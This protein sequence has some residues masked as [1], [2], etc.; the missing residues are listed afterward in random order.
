[1]APEEESAEDGLGHEVDDTVEDSFGVRG[2]DIA[3]L[4]QAP[5]DGIQE[6]DEDGPDADD[7]VDLQNIGTENASVATT[8]E[9]NS[10]GDK[11]EGYGAECEVSPLVGA[12]DQGTNKTSYNHN[13]VDENG[14]E[15]S[16]R[17]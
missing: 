6:P 3:T 14:V 11:E 16:W 7:G 10:P 13:L 12:L 15:D 2:N 17:R 4:R 8:L 1:M 5:G 9:H